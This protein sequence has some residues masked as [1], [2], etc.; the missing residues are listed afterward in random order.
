MSFPV[1]AACAVARCEI[2]RAGYLSSAHSSVVREST[3]DVCSISTA[4]LSGT[5]GLL[6]V[7][8]LN[9]EDHVNTFFFF[10]SPE[11]KSVMRSVLPP[12]VEQLYRQTTHGSE[13]AMSVAIVSSVVKT[14]SS[15]IYL[16]RVFQKFSSQISSPCCYRRRAAREE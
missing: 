16:P 5:P 3:G 8:V 15:K 6:S 12:K 14:C 13:L 10:P 11:S 1:G 9:D 2:S 7:R 4:G